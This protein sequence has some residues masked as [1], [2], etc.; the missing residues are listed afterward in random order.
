MPARDDLSTSLGTRCRTGDLRIHLFQRST[1]TT[2]RSFTNLEQVRAL[3]QNFTSVPVSIVTI[4]G[5]TPLASQADAFRAFNVLVTP[6]GSQISNIIFSDPNTTAIVE[7]LPVVRDIAF[8]INAVDAKFASYVVSTGHTPAPIP[9]RS[10]PVCDEGQKPV[11]EHCLYD[12]NLGMW[13]CPDEWKSQLT[14]CDTLVD[15][16]ILE[17]HLKKAVADLCQRQE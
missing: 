14:A 11:D 3:L 12:D 6:H 2:V 16:S 15:L 1:G 13:T 10:N 17:R 4:N 8:Y 5:S 9:G 7:V